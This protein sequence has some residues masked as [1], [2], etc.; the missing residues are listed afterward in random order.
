MKKSPFFA[1]VAVVLLSAFAPHANAGT[2]TIGN[3]PSFLPASS[4]T[5]NTIDAELLHNPSGLNGDVVRLYGDSMVAPAEE[6]PRILIGGDYH[7]NASDVFSVAYNFTINLNSSEPITLT[8]GAQAI[9]SGMQETF[10]MVLV[11]APG[12]NHY[13]GVITGP[14]FS[15]A[16]SGTWQGR[17]FFNFSSPASS[18]TSSTDNPDPGNLLVRLRAVDFQLVAV[19]EPSSVVLFGAGLVAFGFFALRRRSVV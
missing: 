12:Q 8:L 9:F 10:N 3:G 13:Q 11:I 14:T 17:L 15:L 18:S 5:D 19:P 2:L 6:S 4:F 16:T 7:A 1:G